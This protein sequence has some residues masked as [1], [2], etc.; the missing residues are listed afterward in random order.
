LRI[1]DRRQGCDAVIHS[2]E[3]MN[4]RVAGISGQDEADNLPPSILQ[5]LV[6]ARP[7]RQEQTYA[8]APVAFAGEVLTGCRLDTFFAYDRLD[9]GDSS[10]GKPPQRI[11][12][13]NDRQLV[14]AIVSGQH[15]APRAG[16]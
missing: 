9:R 7:A 12:P 1:C 6:A 11:E 5:G 8:I 15:H 2:G 10:L 13:P 4:M 16:V 14:T 3:K